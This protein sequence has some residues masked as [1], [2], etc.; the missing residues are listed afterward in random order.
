MKLAIC[1]I[2]VG[3]FIGMVYLTDIDYISCKA[4][5]HIQIGEK[6]YWHGGYG[7]DA[8]RLLLDYA[9][10]QKN[11]LRIEAIVLEDNMGSRKLHEKLGYRQE[12]FLRNSVYKDG[13]YKNQVYYALLKSEYKSVDL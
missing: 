11:L 2:D 8:M 9:F 12:G 13:R 6:N 3:E 10:N 4:T 5:S 1:T 7:T